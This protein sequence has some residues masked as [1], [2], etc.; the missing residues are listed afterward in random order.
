MALKGNE[1][2]SGYLV[3]FVHY[4]IKQ[5]EFDTIAKTKRIA[6]KIKKKCK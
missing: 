5:A 3:L 2:Q 4:N 1:M 6:V